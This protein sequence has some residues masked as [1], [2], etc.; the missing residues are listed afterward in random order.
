MAGSFAV[1]IVLSLIGV[2]LHLLVRLAQR[3]VLFWMDTAGDR[4]ISA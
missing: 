3:R 4:T 2:A 1:L